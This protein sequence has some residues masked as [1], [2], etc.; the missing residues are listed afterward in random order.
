MARALAYDPIVRK[1]HTTEA[2]T[3]LK[4]HLKPDMEHPRA[5]YVEGKCPRCKHDV[6]Y[7]HLLK[8]VASKLAPGGGRGYAGPAPPLDEVM[9]TELAHGDEEFSLRCDCQVPH[10]KTPA[11]KD[12]CGSSFKVH[13]GW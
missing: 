8:I 4:A 3:T 1:I 13:V 6:N 11:G 5:V 7:T 10:P 9:D 12:G 2:R